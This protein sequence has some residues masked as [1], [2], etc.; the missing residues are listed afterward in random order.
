M[1]WGHF[2]PPLHKLLMFNWPEV[3]Q[4]CGGARRCAATQR[5][6]LQRALSGQ[7]S[8]LYVSPEAFEAVA[9]LLVCLCAAGA[10]RTSI[11]PPVWAAS[12]STTCSLSVNIVH[13]CVADACTWVR[14]PHS[15][16]PV[17][18]PRTEPK[19][20]PSEPHFQNQGSHASKLATIPQ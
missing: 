1:A 6:A 17:R 9:P 11:H 2:Y 4:L 18:Y 10:G 7:Y 16:R 3:V 14:P 13:V 12:P 8:L 15:P 5:V 19:A 20:L